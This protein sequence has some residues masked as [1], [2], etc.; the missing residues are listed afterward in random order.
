MPTIDFAAIVYVMHIVE[1]V[2]AQRPVEER[3]WASKLRLCVV[4]A[5]HFKRHKEEKRV[6]AR[7]T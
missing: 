5:S 1:V 6:P 4:A 7:Q 3:S 2:I